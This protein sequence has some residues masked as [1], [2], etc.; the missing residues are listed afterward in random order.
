MFS[1]SSR[2]TSGPNPGRTVLLDQAVD[3]MGVSKRTL[4]YW[5]RDGR[6]QTI[7]TRCG[8][9]RVYLSSIR[10]FLENQSRASGEPVPAEIMARLQ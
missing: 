1:P 4:Y 2:S 9:Q 5:I 10:E 3:L 6:L 7:R 8:S